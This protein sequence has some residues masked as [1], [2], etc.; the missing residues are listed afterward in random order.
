MQRK[1]IKL[2]EKFGDPPH[3]TAASE[4]CFQKAKVHTFE[5][6]WKAPLHMMFDGD[7]CTV[8]KHWYIPRNSS[9]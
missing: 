9:N 4:S 2:R 1:R 8:L 6:T 5:N 7:L 3:T